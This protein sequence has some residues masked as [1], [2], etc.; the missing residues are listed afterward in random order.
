[1]KQYDK[2]IHINRLRINYNNVIFSCT[3]VL[4]LNSM[5]TVFLEKDR[6]EEE[7]YGRLE[8]REKE[9]N[10]GWGVGKKRSTAT[11]TYSWFKKHS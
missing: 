7:G 8:R 6:R 11:K 4:V 2:T 5:L 1:M 10:G 3:Y 9:T